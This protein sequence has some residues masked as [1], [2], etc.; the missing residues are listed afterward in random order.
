MD[1][2][3]KVVKR[4]IDQ[5]G[6]VRAAARQVQI[7][8]GYLVRLRDGIKTNPGPETLRKLGIKQRV[9]YSRLG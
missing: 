6:G 8:A 7:D 5:H 4:L 1:N 9:I 2:L 3:Q